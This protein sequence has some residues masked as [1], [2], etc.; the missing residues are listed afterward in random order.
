M[1]DTFF[2][3]TTKESELG[4][5]SGE[6]NY[7]INPENLPNSSV[8]IRNN[9]FRI[10][11]EGDGKSYSFHSP[12][13]DLLGEVDSRYC[14]VGSGVYVYFNYI[15]ANAR[16]TNWEGQLFEKQ[17]SYYKLYYIIRMK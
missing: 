4:K 17:P 12:V 16:V 14:D 10:I 11:D 3:G 6:N 7:K 15:S 2:Q 1:T 13:K 8:T 5:I 9:T